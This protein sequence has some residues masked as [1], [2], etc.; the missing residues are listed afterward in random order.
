MAI[1]VN[2]LELIRKEINDAIAAVAAKHNMTMSLGKI[3]YD[4]VSFKSEIKATVIST[5]GTDLKARNDWDHYCK[6]FWLKSEDFG[7]T[8]VDAGETY[9]ICGV[10]PRNT[11]F[12]ILAKS[13]KGVTYKFPDDVIRKHLNRTIDVSNVTVIDR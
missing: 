12:P 4:E 13:I 1:T 3:T 2:Q 7:K 9:T 8:F 6:L 10:K 11:K 5:D